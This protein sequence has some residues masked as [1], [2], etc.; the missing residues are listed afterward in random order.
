MDSWLDLKVERNEDL[1]TWMEEKKYE[2]EE[3]RGLTA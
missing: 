3:T 2:L 1:A